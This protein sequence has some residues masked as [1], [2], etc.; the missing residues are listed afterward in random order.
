M[1]IHRKILIFSGFVVNR[2]NPLIRVVRYTA[3]NVG[4]SFVNRYKQNHDIRLLNDSYV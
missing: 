3:G 2:S 4:N 1:K